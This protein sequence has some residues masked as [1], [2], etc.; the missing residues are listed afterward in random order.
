MY[1]RV[2][3]KPASY[4]WKVLS[5]RSARVMNKHVR[6]FNFLI[7]LWLPFEQYFSLRMDLQKINEISLQKFKETKKHTSQLELNREYVIEQ[8]VP[9]K[10]E[11]GE[12]LVA[13]LEDFQIFIPEHLTPVI[14]EF[15]GSKYSNE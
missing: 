12:A 5:S 13:I 3:F 4:M 15:N 1:F 2:V 6:F 7:V 14:S 8:L 11:F 9:V 10:T